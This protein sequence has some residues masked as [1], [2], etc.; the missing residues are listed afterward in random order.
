MVVINYLA[1]RAKTRSLW[2]CEIHSAAKQ[3]N[4]EGG[5]DFHLYQNLAAFMLLTTVAPVERMVVTMVVPRIFS[6]ALML[7]SLMTI[8]S[9]DFAGKGMFT[10]TNQVKMMFHLK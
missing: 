10:S 4:N 8:L 1:A 6:A 5:H 2:N 7:L 3:Q 9:S